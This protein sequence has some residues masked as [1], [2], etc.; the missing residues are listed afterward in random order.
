MQIQ[1]LLKEA[2]PDFTESGEDNIWITK[3]YVLRRWIGILGMALPFLLWFFLWFDT[4]TMTP[5]ESISH[6]YFTRVGGILV[7]IVGV[8]AIFLI[9][10]KG[11]E[12]I[13]LIISTTAGLFALCLLLFP[14]SNIT[15]ICK[16]NDKFYSV[17][18]LRNSDGRALF[19][20][21]SAAIFLLCLSYMSLFLFTKTKDVEKMGK[22]K[23]K[24]NVVY[25][26]CG[27]VMILAILVILLG[28]LKVINPVWYQE[29]AMT[30]WMEAVAIES[31]G[32]AWLVKG[33]TI[34]RD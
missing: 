31:F 27:I 26:I 15:E 19:H 2:K 3:A 9:I 28:F 32:F 25:I 12:L 5:L 11:K 16:D 4:K 1:E 23:K 13:D 6:Y 14:T 20:Y 18:I 29:H 21:L 24:R 30:F 17:T 22:Q 33:E 7:L 8:L 10:Y 34:F